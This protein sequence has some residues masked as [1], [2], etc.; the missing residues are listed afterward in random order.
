MAVKS[1]GDPTGESID[2]DFYSDYKDELARVFSEKVDS[3]F[4]KAMLNSPPLEGRTATQDMMRQQIESDRMNIRQEAARQSLIM[5]GV[6]LVAGAE[7]TNR[8]DGSR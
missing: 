8:F 5:T 6:S 7:I 1:F 3:A 2:F 4:M